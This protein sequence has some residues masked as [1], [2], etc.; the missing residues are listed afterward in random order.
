MLLITNIVLLVLFSVKKTYSITLKILTIVQFA[1]YIIISLV[2]INSSL[3]FVDFYTIAFVVIILMILSLLQVLNLFFISPKRYKRA[4][5]VVS[6][7]VLI[8]LSV[9]SVLFWTVSRFEFEL[10]EDG[11]S[12]SIV[13]IESDI[14]TIRIP[15]TYKGLPITKINSNYYIYQNIQEIIFEEDSNIEIIEKW[16]NGCK[17]TKITLP[18][19]LHTIGDYAFCYCYLEEVYIPIEVTYIGV[20]AFNNENLIIYCEIESKPDTWEVNW[21]NQPKEIIWGYGG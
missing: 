2:Y 20:W 16:S 4:S 14:P 19:S 1:L 9:Y 10:N 15:S 8:L 5:I 17:L 3:E 13:S 18:S 21:C 6:S 11:E 7:I 12:Y